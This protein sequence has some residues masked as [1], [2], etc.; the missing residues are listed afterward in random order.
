MKL[1]AWTVVVGDWEYGIDLKALTVWREFVSDH[2]G[3]DELMSVK[4]KLVVGRNYHCFTVRLEKVITRT[5]S[6]QEGSDGYTD[7]N[8]CEN[9]ECD[10]GEY[11]S[12][13]FWIMPSWDWVY[14]AAD[15]A[16]AKWHDFY[17]IYLD[18]DPA[19]CRACQKAGRL[20]D[21]LHWTGLG[22]QTSLDARGFHR[23]RVVSE[24]GAGYNCLYVWTYEAVCGLK[25]DVTIDS[26]D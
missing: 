2:D 12:Y 16:K 20:N 11:R 6:C 13:P 17:V 15:N 25:A 21:G 14:K 19:V 9:E 1:N 24:R 18:N 4:Y 7:V 10:G 23:A 22:S 5:H 8:D 26:G 3:P